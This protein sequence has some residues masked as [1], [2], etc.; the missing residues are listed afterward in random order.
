M[1][2][3]DRMTHRLLRL[4]SRQPMV[5]VPSEMAPPHSQTHDVVD[6]KLPAGQFA[7]DAK[8]LAYTLDAELGN[9][10]S[11][12]RFSLRQRATRTSFWLTLLSGLALYLVHLFTRG[13]YFGSFGA[14]N[15]FVQEDVDAICPQIGPL[16]PDVHSALLS[17]LEALYGTEEFRLKAFESLGGA[18]RVP[19]VSS[20]S[21]LRTLMRI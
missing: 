14:G 16:S 8:S 5:P 4:F 7:G 19:Y 10:A 9:T 20:P 12:P 15:K 11:P 6:E 1:R 2:S 21:S 17:T 13:H 3:E 18:V